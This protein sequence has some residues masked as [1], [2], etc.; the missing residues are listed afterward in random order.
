M[1]TVVES[2]FQREGDEIGE[3][4]SFSWLSL[5]ALFSSLVGLFSIYY[6]QIMPFAVLGTAIGALT[7]LLANR[8]DLNWISRLTGSL[9]VIVGTIAG[10]SGFFGRMLETSG[11]VQQARLISELYLK[12]LSSNDWDRV[13]YFVGYKAPEP[14][15]ENDGQNPQS[16]ILKLKKSVETDPVHV[17]IAK[18]GDEAKWVY[19]GLDGEYSGLMGYT[20]RLRF[21][22]VGQT[23]PSE[24]IVFA[25]KDCEKFE[26]K[27]TV[28][29]FVDSLDRKQK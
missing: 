17:E 21:R 7:L 4:K 29:W 2:K 10:S 22:D 8:W 26:T 27:E 25:R 11:D 5:A 9:A 18:R 12:S 3:A 15:D 6:V 14:G 24:Y 1:S 16:S 23:I 13:H 28:R 20:Y 19:T